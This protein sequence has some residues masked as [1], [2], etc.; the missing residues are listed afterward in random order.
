M[1]LHCK[2]S[3]FQQFLQ[4]SYGPTDWRTDKPASAYAMPLLKLTSCVWSLAVARLTCIKLT[5]PFGE[6]K[7]DRPHSWVKG[8]Q[9][10]WL[11]EMGFDGMG[12]D[13][14]CDTMG[15]DVLCD[16]MWSYVKLWNMWSHVFP[17][18]SYLHKW[19]SQSPLWFWETIDLQ[20][21]SSIWGGSPTHFP[22]WHALFREM[23]TSF[24]PGYPIQF[25]RASQRVRASQRARS[26]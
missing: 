9:S 23:R 8:G 2:I 21:G 4:K 22:P 24:S 18:S 20:T 17:I 12:W 10:M 25:L 6:I 1:R 16:T 7:L 5:A 19:L 13:V 26:S 11:L 15:W 3:H 14:L